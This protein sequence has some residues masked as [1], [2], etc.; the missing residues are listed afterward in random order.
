MRR[1]KARELR[2]IR[3]LSEVVGIDVAIPT[4]HHV[5]VVNLEMGSIRSKECSKEVRVH[6]VASCEFDDSDGTPV[7]VS[8]LLAENNKFGELDFWKVTD[9]P[10]LD[11]PIH[12]D[13]LRNFIIIKDGQTFSVNHKC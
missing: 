7:V 10:I 3:R 2:L 1:I 6:S 11:H 12:L 9:E 13:A 4:E 8:L 5:W